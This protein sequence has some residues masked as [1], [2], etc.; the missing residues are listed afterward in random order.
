MKRLFALTLAL[1]ALTGG[2]SLAEEEPRP[3][4]TI[5]I[6]GLVTIEVPE[7]PEI[8][9]P[10]VPKP[11]ATKTP[12]I[13]VPKVPDVDL[14]GAQELPGAATDAEEDAVEAP[15]DAEVEAA[16]TALGDGVYRR[17]WQTL[18]GGEP[19]RE[20]SRGDAVKGL[21]QT[22]IAFG[23][24]IAADGIF[25]PRTLNALNTVQTDLGLSKTRSLD[26]ERYGAL[27]K[28]LAERKQE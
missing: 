19:L 1:L 8:D 25:G 27:L 4:E 23:Q 2:A 22:L 14:P 7:M 5:V 13:D 16:L 15:A 26:A 11:S 10:D 17:T 9:V 28:G 18:L 3:A 21:Q 20:G 12:K 24:K 6:P